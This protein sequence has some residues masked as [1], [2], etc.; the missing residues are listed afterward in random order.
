MKT[1]IVKK[2]TRIMGRNVCLNCGAD[3]SKRRTNSKF[4]SPLCKSVY[5]FEHEGKPIYTNKSE[6]YM[7]NVF[8]ER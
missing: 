8:M 1:I 6:F 4:C 3:L 7:T 5:E 2:P